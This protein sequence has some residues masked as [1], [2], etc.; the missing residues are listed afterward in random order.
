MS[1]WQAMVLVFVQACVVQAALGAFLSKR[2]QRM[3]AARSRQA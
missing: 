2:Q 1:D 3:R